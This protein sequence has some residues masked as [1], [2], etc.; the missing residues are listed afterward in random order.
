MKCIC[1]IRK[2]MT[3][4]H[5]EWCVEHPNNKK[6]KKEPDEVKWF[7]EPPAPKSTPVMHPGIDWDSFM[8]I[9]STFMHITSTI[10]MPTLQMLGRRGVDW[11]TN[12]LVYNNTVAIDF[13]DAGDL[14]MSCVS[15]G[16]G[17]QLVHS[18]RR[19]VF[20]H[21]TFIIFTGRSFHTNV[22]ERHRP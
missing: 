20:P 17:L 9:T 21:G 22:P 5:E 7:D 10:N 11:L 4:G 12:N 13:N 15:T 18:I 3:D 2:L 16:G 19:D 14:F 8:Q 6:I 1:D